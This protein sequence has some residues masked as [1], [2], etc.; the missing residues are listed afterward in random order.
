MLITARDAAWRLSLG[1]VGRGGVGRRVATGVLAAGL[2]GRPIIT[3]AA[4][5]YDS[6][7]VQDLLTWPVL[8]DDAVKT[9]CPHGL[10]L[11][12]RPLL[13]PVDPL[14][15][16][17]ADG[18]DLSVFTAIRMRVLLIERHGFLP[19]VVTVGGFVVATAE[20]TDVVGTSR[21]YTLVLREAGEWAAAF[22]RRRHLVRHGC[23]WLLQ[24]WAPVA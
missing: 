12:R 20:I 10:F 4:H 6:E 5:L 24:E 1:G 19:L 11:A 2:A 3:P 14:G 18:W 16:S 21:C 23:P 7:R 9:A 22:H 15:S 13:A 17:I 8:D